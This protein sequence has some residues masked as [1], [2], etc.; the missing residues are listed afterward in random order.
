[1]K[2]KTNQVVWH[3]RPFNAFGMNYEQMWI[4]ILNESACLATSFTELTLSIQSEFVDEAILKHAQQIL[5]A[6]SFQLGHTTIQ[7]QR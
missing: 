4:S 2:T 1:M 3:K 7:Q 6:C 5:S